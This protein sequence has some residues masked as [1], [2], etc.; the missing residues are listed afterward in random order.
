MAI[1]DSYK[2]KSDEEEISFEENQEE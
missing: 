2:F 1:D